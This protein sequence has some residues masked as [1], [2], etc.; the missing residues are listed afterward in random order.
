MEIKR[1]PTGQM[2]ANCYLIWNKNTNNA[3][4]IDPGDSAEKIISYID[5]NKLN[6]K[7]ILLTHGHFD[8]IGALNKIRKYTNAPVYVHE[9]D[10]NCVTDSNYNL[11]VLVNKNIFCDNDAEFTINDGDIIGKGEF[12]IQVIHTPGHSKGSVC[13]LMGNHL[14]SGD[15]L[16]PIGIGRT[17]LYG[18]DYDEL[19]DSIKN[20]LL[21]L[22]DSLI[23]YP[24]HGEITSFSK[25]KTYH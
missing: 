5:E 13:Y 12:D 4:V 11:S 21:I 7:K 19:I 25:V 17:D 24:G 23:M 8:H 16:F 3:I 18:G 22:P 15:T 1:I 2:M 10:A 14:F 20:K 9:N 6:V